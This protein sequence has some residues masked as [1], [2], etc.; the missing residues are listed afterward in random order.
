MNS[1]IATLVK[2]MKGMEEG[3]PDSVTQTM[4]RE[5][6]ATIRPLYGDDYMLEL[7]QCEV[8]A[9]DQHVRMLEEHPGDVPEVV[10]EARRVMKYLRKIHAKLDSE[11]R[12]I[13][14]GHCG[15]ACGGGCPDCSGG[16]YDH[17]YEVS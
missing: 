8:E 17:A 11:W 2:L 3:Y 7:A 16:G 13:N 1:T 9:Q 12:K 5:F 15:R 10:Q 6:R 14:M 4:R